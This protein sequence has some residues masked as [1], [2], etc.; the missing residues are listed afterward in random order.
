MIPEAGTRGCSSVPA[1]PASV[2][3]QTWFTAAIAQLIP[4]RVQCCAMKC[5]P[6]CFQAKI[7]R[8]WKTFPY[9]YGYQCL[10]IEEYILL[11]QQHSYCNKLVKLWLNSKTICHSTVVREGFHKIKDLKSE[12][13]VHFTKPPPPFQEVNHLYFFLEK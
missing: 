8:S 11:A 3:T 7:E 10:Y 6:L 5:H 2:H 13:A 12:P 4:S 1:Q 9:C